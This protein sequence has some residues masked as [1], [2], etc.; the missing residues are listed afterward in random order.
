MAHDDHRVDHDHGPL[1]HH[2]SERR[3]RDAE[4][5]DVDEEG[6]HDDVRHESAHGDRQRRPGVLQAP[7]QAG[8]REHEQHGG[9]AE[10]REREVGGGLRRHRRRRAEQSDEERRSEPAR[11]GEDDA[12]AERQPAA[13]D[14]GGH[15]PAFVAGP[16]SSRH[17]GGGRV[18]EED[19]ETDDRL[20]HRARDP[21]AGKLRDPQVAHHRRVRQQ[22]ERLGDQRPERGHGEPQDLPIERAAEDDVHGATTLPRTPTCRAVRVSEALPTVEA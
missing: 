8:H 10:H 15:G 19:H 18:R 13:V 3:A 11:D 17:R 22:E 6:V 5:G 1:R 14:A 7:Q 20:Q 9:E 16:E 2:G 12:Q 21:E 4:A